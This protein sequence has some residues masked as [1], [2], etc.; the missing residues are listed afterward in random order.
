MAYLNKGSVNKALTTPQ[1]LDELT[2]AYTG[3]MYFSGLR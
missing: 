3:W 1:H 2:Q